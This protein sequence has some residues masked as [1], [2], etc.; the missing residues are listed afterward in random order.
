A[1]DWT[2]CRRYR[3]RDVQRQLH[4][5]PESVRDEFLRKESGAGVLALLPALRE[6]MTWFRREAVRRDGR[7]L[8]KLS[9][10]WAPADAA[11]ARV[12]PGRPWPDGLPRQCRLYLDPATAWPCRFEWWGPDAPRPADALLIQMEFRDPVLNRPLSAAAGARAFRPDADPA[13]FPEQTTE[14]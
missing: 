8:L 3:V 4:S 14:V 11:T 7:G 9:G 6:R 2:N 13:L 10:A 5:A 12:R 1:G